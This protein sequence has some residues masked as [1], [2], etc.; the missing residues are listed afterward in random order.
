MSQY[1]SYLGPSLYREKGADE[2]RFLTP[3]SIQHATRK[4]SNPTS[5]W[6]VTPEPR[7]L[8]NPL[9]LT[10]PRLSTEM[11]QATYEWKEEM[12]LAVE[13]CLKE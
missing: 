1:V 7:L 6:F 4:I 5:W 2:S 10:D 13:R 9:L 12:R 8:S 11:Y 3:E